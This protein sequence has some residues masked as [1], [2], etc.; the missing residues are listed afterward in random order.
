M[1][2]RWHIPIAA[3]A[4]ALG[5][6]TAAAGP[7]AASAPAHL[8]TTHTHSATAGVA[9]THPGATTHPAG[10]PA[11]FNPGGMGRGTTNALAKAPGVSNETEV[12]TPNWSGFVESGADGSYTSVSDE[13]QQATLVCDTDSVQY[14]SFWVGLDG[15]N[16]SSV[17]QTGTL[18]VCD[19]TTPYYY[20]WYEMYP[21][22][23]VYY[24][25]TVEA[26]LLIYGSVVF[27][28]TDTYTLS[29]E[30]INLDWTQTT[31]V[32][33]PG[34]A[35]ASAEVITEAP[36]SSSGV[37]PLAE[38]ERAHYRVSFINGAYMGSDGGQ[39]PTPLYIVDPSGLAEDSTAAPPS[40]IGGFYNDWI[41]SS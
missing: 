31:T 25:V 38:F 12:A 10:V 4:L 6:L 22:A 37:L 14:V 35:N 27:S 8:A 1:T 19:G 41:Q 34:L 23:P 32:N 36:S 2:R 9:T 15:Y 26:G 17:E 21:A 13:W 3:L 30:G 40:P 18:G 33:E 24:N 39:N 20:A 16:G 11:G 28:G 7:A 29:L 5:G